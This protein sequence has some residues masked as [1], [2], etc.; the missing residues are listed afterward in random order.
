MRDAR[1]D[2]APFDFEILPQPDDTTCGPTCLHGVYRFYGDPI[3]LAQVIREVVPLEGGGTLAVQ[4]GCHALRRGYRATLYTYNLTVFD[5]TWFAPPQ[6]DLAERLR[7]QAALKADPKLRAETGFYLEFLSLGGRVRFEELSARLLR[8]HLRRGQPLLTGLSGTYLYGC[9]REVGTLELDYDDA[10]GQPVG[11]FVVIHAYDPEQRLVHIADPF[12]D[13]PAFER[14][15]YAV[16]LDRVLGAILLGVL[17]YDANLLL[18]EPP[19][20]PAGPGGAP[21]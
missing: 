10:R 11:H 5:P 15:H 17:T 20:R 16:G 6:P 2:A 19:S 1:A 3:E 4:L 18:V 12:H 21:R 7:T 13:N 9:A 14:R 8:R